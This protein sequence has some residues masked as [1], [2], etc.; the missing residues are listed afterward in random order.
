MNN[1]VGCVPAVQGAL[2]FALLCLTLSVEFFSN[3]VR[4]DA[5]DCNLYTPA[6]GRG[7]AGSKFRGRGCEGCGRNEERSWECGPACILLCLVPRPW[8]HMQSGVLHP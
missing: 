6:A 5:H 1:G 3:S 4:C 8:M 7:V 2:L